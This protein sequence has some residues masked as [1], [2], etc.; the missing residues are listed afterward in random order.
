VDARS[1]SRELTILKHC[2][3]LRTAIDFLTIRKADTEHAASV[4]I[5][6]ICLGTVT[7]NACCIES[8]ECTRFL[9]S[10]LPF[11]GLRWEGFRKV[12]RLLCKRLGKRLRELE[13][14]SLDAYRA[15]LGEDPAEWHWLDHATHIPISRFYRDRTV[16]DALRDR[17][18][19]ELAERAAARGDGVVRCW[20]AGCASGE[21]PYSIAM[22][23]NLVV[24]P[25]YPNISISIVATD[26]D[27]VLLD[28]AATGCYN[29]TSLRELPDDWIARAFDRR[30]N[31]YCLRDSFK[32]S[33]HAERQ[34]LRSQ[35]PPG[36]FDLI[37]CRNFALTYFDEVV[38]TQIIDAIT[39][40]LAQHGILIIGRD[41]RLPGGGAALEPVVN[42]PCCYIRAAR[43]DR[44]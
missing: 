1:A 27:Q 37:L 28:R 13:L 4:A 40:R 29:A 36:L 22:I 38:Q 6:R 20:S 41:E 24:A 39:D 5:G 17:L 31:L 34:D 10:A 32:N 16:Y 30:G 25:R 21:E 26:R 2:L 8:S 11:L 43:A 14:P 35:R 19:G 12:R 44:P 23:W 3:I 42:A 33:V 9:Q 15:R 18:L 7:R